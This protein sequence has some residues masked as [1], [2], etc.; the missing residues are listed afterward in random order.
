MA[1]SIPILQVAF[2]NGTAQ[3]V[4][5]AVSGQSVSIALNRCTVTAPLLWAQASTVAQVDIQVSFDNGNSFVG[6]ASFSAIGGIL[7]RF[8]VTAPSSG[9]KMSFD[10]P[11]TNLI[12]NLTVTSGPLMTSGTVTVQ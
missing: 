10:T 12:V 7:N 8:G 1:T 2:A 9:V 5:Q 3:L 4:N 6:V 11:I